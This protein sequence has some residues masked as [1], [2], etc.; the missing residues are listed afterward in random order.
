M[1]ALLAAF[2]LSAAPPEAP[3]LLPFLS[4]TA[5]GAV[6][7]DLP[8]LGEEDFAAVERLI[9]AGERDPTGTPFPGVKATLAGAGA[10]GGVYMVADPAVPDGAMY[11]IVPAADEAAARRIAA[12]VPPLREPGTRYVPDPLG[13]VERDGAAAVIAGVENLPAP[14]ADRPDPAAAWAAAG[15]APVKL[16]YLPTAGQRAALETL[17]PPDGPLPGRTLA[18]IRWAAAG[19]TPT[20]DVPIRATV[21]A[22]DPAAA[23]ALVELAANA[24][25]ARG[26][27][28]PPAV[29]P[30]AAGDRVTLNL[31]AAGIE[32][33]LR[34][35]GLAAA[36]D[37]QRAAANRA[38]GLNNLKQLAL[39]LHNFHASHRSFPPTA[40]YAA[41]GTPLLSWRVHLLPYL[42]AADLHR[43]FKFD[44]PWDSAHNKALLTEMP[45]VFGSPRAGSEPGRTLYQAPFGPGLAFEGTAGAPLGE[46]KDGTSNTI[47]VVEAAEPVPWTKP[48]DWSPDLTGGA[49][50]ADGLRTDD[51]GRAAVIFADGSARS[52]SA[53]EVSRETWI[54]L[55][56]RAGG[57]VVGAEERP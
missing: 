12:G 19:L 23:T 2:V 57:E 34:V 51:D 29:T 5:W 37:A 21:R 47:L 18:G 28:L 9:N 15:E 36:R 38:R 10:T 42:D 50:P 33:L 41:D 20:A 1:S 4:P 27:A 49:N 25:A 31:D 53:E 6:Y 55:L 14:A 11:M 40:S 17:L 30:T 56:T 46:F 44:E 22:A 52:L 16:L 32:T 39:A 3:P 13:A 48:A 43:R 8:R 24:A 54:K 7:L 45:A 35:T 26:S